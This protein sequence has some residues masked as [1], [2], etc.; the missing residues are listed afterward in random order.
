M[1]DPGKIKA[2]LQS[3]TLPLIGAGAGGLTG[4]IFSDEGASL[5]GAL[6]GALLGAGAGVGGT[7]IKQFDPSQAALA[8]TLLG[9]GVGGLIGQR[10]VSP[11]SVEKMKLNELEK[12]EKRKKLEEEDEAAR[13]AAEEAGIPPESVVGTGVDQGMK[14]EQSAKK[15]SDM[16]I[17]EKANEVREALGLNKR[18]TAPAPEAMSD[19]DFQEHANAFEFG[20]DSFC[21]DAGIEK[22]ALAQAAQVPED[23]LT[24][25]TLA[26]LANQTEEKN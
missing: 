13:T 22:K 24:L 10:R 5:R 26:W 20:I 17:A 16:S 18:A 21:K 25:A 15:E 1:L 9:G 11:W 7:L 12:M 2:L 14:K 6:Q 4:G 8:A 19:A 23:H 3:A